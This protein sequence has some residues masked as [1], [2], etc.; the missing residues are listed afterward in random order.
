[1]FAALGDASRLRLV[2]RLCDGGPLS[3]V[4]LTQGARVSRQAVTKHLRALERAGLVC[5]RRH[6]RERIWTLE[7]QRLADAGLYLAQISAQWDAAIGRLRDL[8]EE[9]DRRTDG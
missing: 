8:V 5:S 1:M 3:I 7:T 2:A 9:P 4:R 6:G